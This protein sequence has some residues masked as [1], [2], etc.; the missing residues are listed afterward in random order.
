MKKIILLIVCLNQLHTIKAQN[1]GIGTTTPQATLDVKGNVRMGGISKYMSYDSASGKI[2]WTNASL[3]VPVSQYLVQHSAS[4]EGLYYN[5]GQLEYRNQLG[6]A[7]FFSNWTNGNGYFSGKLGIN[8]TAPQFPLT[9]NNSLGDKISLWTDGTP[10]HYGFGVQSSLLQ[11]FAKTSLDDIGFG[12]GSSTSFTEAM[13]IKG[14]GKVGIGII[15]PVTRLHIYDGASGGTPFTFSR[16]AVESNGHTYLNLL[17]PDAN[18]T[19][20]LFGKAS[21]AASGG[22]LYNNSSTPNGFQFRNNGNLT[23]MVIDNNGN[24]G[25]GNP[26]PQFPLDINGRM[27]LSGT[28][29]NDPGMW[30]NDGGTDRAF[31]G[32]QNNNQVGFYGSTWGFTMNTLTGALSVNGDAGTAGQLLRSGGSGAAPVWTDPVVSKTQYYQ[33]TISS[34]TL[35]NASP[36]FVVNVPV[37]VYANSIITVSVTVNISTAAYFGCDHGE[38]IMSFEPLGGGGLIGSGGKYQTICGGTA[39]TITS[40]ELPLLDGTG[41]MKVFSA[42]TGIGGIIKFIKNN[43]GP[44]LS[45]GNTLPAVIIVKVIP[46]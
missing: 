12:Y 45:I 7:A 32:L 14:N 3:F 2:T 46:I 36:S 25:I 8:N 35:T 42:G 30:L 33:T 18:E 31:I 26:S 28:N 6:A 23:R 22:I 29:P 13:R 38:L 19:A 1:T 16:V 27:R 5:S 34:V 43:A 17:S 41:G 44:D 4:A 24:V 39:N 21:N 20:I 15:N 40:G 9:L 11:M 37:T 10:T